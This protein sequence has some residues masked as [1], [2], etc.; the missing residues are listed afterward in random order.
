MKMAADNSVSYEDY[1]GVGEDTNIGKN[2]YSFSHARNYDSFNIKE[3]TDDVWKTIAALDVFI[4]REQP[5]KKIK[6]D[7]V[8]GKKDIAYLL[9]HLLRI[10]V[11]L[12]PIMPQTSL[13][14]QDLVKRRQMPTAPL[15]A[16]K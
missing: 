2:F 15:F 14:I 5:F 3:E 9:S 1:D 8:S 16:R 6:S 13:A 7:P 11:R 12:E 10:A 4:Q